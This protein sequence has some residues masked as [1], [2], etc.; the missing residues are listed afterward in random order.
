VSEGNKGAEAVQ[1]HFYKPQAVSLL[2]LGSFQPV[3]TS[4]TVLS[5]E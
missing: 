1:W 2:E 4:F 3:F 5:V